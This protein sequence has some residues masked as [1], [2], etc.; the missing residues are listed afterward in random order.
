MIVDYNYKIDAKGITFGGATFYEY[1]AKGNKGFIYAPYGSTNFEDASTNEGEAFV[2]SIVFTNPQGNDVTLNI[3]VSTD[4]RSLNDAFAQF[5]FSGGFAP[6]SLTRAFST[7][8]TP[9]F[10]AA[11]NYFVPI[12]FKKVIISTTPALTPSN[13][14]QPVYFFPVY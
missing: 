2:S 8:R 1:T 10:G 12:T 14:F 5:N 4:I 13:W 11:T 9:F 6:A 7:L 3:N